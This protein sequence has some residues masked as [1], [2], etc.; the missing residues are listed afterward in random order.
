MGA[1][2]QTTKWDHRPAHDYSL[3]AERLFSL[4][5]TTNLATFLVFLCMP[6]VMR[7][8]GLPGVLYSEIDILNVWE[9]VSDGYVKVR[10]RE[11]ERERNNHARH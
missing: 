8:E 4:R 3:A 7:L 1:M 9:A 5:S 11:R 2:L 6:G 10:E